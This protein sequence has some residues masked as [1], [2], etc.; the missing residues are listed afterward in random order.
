M[1]WYG[2]MV[3]MITSRASKPRVNYRPLRFVEIADEK[4]CKVVK[5]NI[6]V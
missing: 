1:Q 4:T 3:S 6:T 2:L 5:L